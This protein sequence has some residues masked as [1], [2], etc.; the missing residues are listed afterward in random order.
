[1]RMDG[2]IALVAGGGSG[3]GRETA[4]R[5]GEE[6]ATVVVADINGEAAATAAAEIGGTAVTLDVASSE[7]V[8]AAMREVGERFGKLDVL[9][10]S[11]GVCIPGNVLTLTEEEWNLQMDVNVKGIF[12]LSRAA[13]P[14]LKVNHERG[15]GGS[16][17]VNVASTS[18]YWVFPGQSA[19]TASKGGAIMLTKT[20][21]LEG[22]RDRVRVNCVCPGPVRTPMSAGIAATE[23]DP[24]G[25]VATY[26]RLMPL[27]RLGEPRDIAN[28]ILFLASD[29]ASWATGVSLVLDGG[30][31]LGF[32]GSFPEYS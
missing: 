1:M 11:A 14:L 6:G 24:E 27:G 22:A 4:V 19:Y 20:M 29:E 2:K 3:I 15:E 28:G 26:V 8:T 16:A 9:V 32:W 25:A 23:T 7:S 5:F 21:A 17:L 30:W 18:G 31:T 12:L 10:N 13:W